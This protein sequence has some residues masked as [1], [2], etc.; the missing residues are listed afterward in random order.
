MPQMICSFD[1][2]RG[3][4]G[5]GGKNESLFEMRRQNSKYNIPSSV[6]RRQIYFLA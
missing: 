3:G 4:G 1:A 5:G 2:W 6:Q